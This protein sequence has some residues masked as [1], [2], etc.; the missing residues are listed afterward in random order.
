MNPP[1]KRRGDIRHTNTSI[2]SKNTKLVLCLQLT[3]EYKEVNPLGQVPALH[4]EG[5]VLTQSVGEQ[6]HY[7]MFSFIE[8]RG[9]FFLVTFEQ[10]AYFLSVCDFL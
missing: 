9:V 8:H 7:E 1:Y 3:E 5:T 6:T 2:Y 4:I 10:W